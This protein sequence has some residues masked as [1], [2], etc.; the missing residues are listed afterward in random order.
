MNFLYDQKL[1]SVFHL[2]VVAPIILLVGLDKFP[3]EYKTFLVYL[4]IF[5]GV[6]SFLKLANLMSWTKKVKILSL[7]E[8]MEG[9]KVTDCNAVHHVKIFDSYPG[10]SHP[11]LKINSGECVIWTNIG[12]LQHSI[13]STANYSHFDGLFASSDL[14]PGQF[15]GV[16]FTTPG[17]YGYFCLDHKGWKH[18]LVIVS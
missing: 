14:F 13:A 5:I 17:K 10:L 2:A 8:G 4:A 15:F 12:E 6:V 11:I 1:A 9:N 7:V 18:G 3:K 16:K